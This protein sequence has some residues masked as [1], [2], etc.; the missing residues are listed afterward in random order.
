ML[1]WDARVGMSQDLIITARWLRKI[2]KLSNVAL[3]ANKLEGDSWAHDEDSLVMENLRDVLRL[4]LGNAIPISALQGDGLADIAILIEK[5]KVEK[6]A[7]HN[8][9]NIDNAIRKA[10]GERN[11]EDQKPLQIAIIGRQNVGK[12]LILVQCS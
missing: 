11:S 1:L 2:G 12:L 6:E 3:I 5:L 8:E 4:G 7:D 10:S 9:E